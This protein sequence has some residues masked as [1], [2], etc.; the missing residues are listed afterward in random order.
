MRVCC[1][2]A[3]VL[4]II[5]CGVYADTQWVFDPVNPVGPGSRDGGML[6]Y[7]TDRDVLV[8]TGLWTDNNWDVYGDS[9]D[10]W[11]LHGDRWIY[12]GAD[13]SAFTFRGYGAFCYDEARGNCVWFGGSQQLADRTETFIWDGN[14][15][16]QQSPSVFP[17]GGWLC[18]Q[19]MA[20]DSSREVCVLVS[21]NETWEWNGTDWAQVTTT[22]Q[23]PANTTGV[24]VY[25][26]YRQVSVLCTSGTNSTIFMDFDGNDWT[27]SNSFSAMPA[28]S[29][30]TMFYDENQHHCIV[31]GGIV[32]WSENLNDTWSYDG[33][34][35]TELTP[36]HTPPAGA[37]HSVYRR[38][39]G[40]GIL[41]QGHRYVFHEHYP[42]HMEILNETW[43]WNGND[44]VPQN[45]TIYPPGRFNSAMAW[46]SMRQSLVVF[47]GQT[48]SFGLFNGAYSDTWEHSV[49]GWTE[50]ATTTHPP[51]N[52]SRY[53][54][55]D[56]IYDP[57]STSCL[58]VTGTD[59]IETWSYNGSDWNQ[60]SVSSITGDISPV[61]CLN[62]DTQT[63]WMVA[64]DNTFTWDGTTWQPVAGVT[65]PEN[66]V[67]LTYNAFLSELTLISYEM[68]NMT[69]EFWIFQEGNWIKRNSGFANITG[70]PEPEIS[71]DPLSQQIV[72]L[73]GYYGGIEY[74]PFLLS[75]DGQSTDV[76]HH[77][78]SEFAGPI[79]RTGATMCATDDGLVSFGGTQNEFGQFSELWNLHLETAC[80]ARHTGDVN[81]DGELTASDAQLCFQ[82]VLG[83]YVAQYRQSCAADCNG[84]GE[85]TATDAQT[86]FL[87][88]LGA[89]SCLH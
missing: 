31:F 56:M 3:F 51:I 35:L 71:Y 73:G 1:I 54:D 64:A 62:T 79:L 30:P 41:T 34:T 69:L 87:S 12:R 13:Q 88:V 70:W 25:D 75:W 82:I 7:D 44:W 4:S 86:I 20:Y 40:E 8:Y 5:T 39:T 68:S 28:R 15:W 11:E 50:V 33:E 47:G 27:N 74:N 57:S 45:P 32:E 52:E 46:D 29:Q 16:T 85:Y 48:C 18:T 60:L 61:I 49:N 23:P 72:I 24:L 14:N 38:R 76:E 81:L 63:V 10:T 65:T 77:R 83:S 6:A 89:E 66:I 43:I 67:D 21:G 37:Y 84:D 53:S 78:H 36:A 2:F 9:Q 22:L 17:P 58:L 80:E 26:H 19:Q 42:Y 55:A 59:P